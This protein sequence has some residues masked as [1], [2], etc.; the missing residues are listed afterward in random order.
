MYNIVIFASG[1]G[2]NAQRIAEYF[3]NKPDFSI[4]RIYCNTKNAGVIKRAE[5]L[6]IPVFIFNRNDFY[7]TQT[8]L[9]QIRSDQPNL[10]VLA[11]FLW[12]IPTNLTSL[13][14]NRII[15]IHPALLPKYGGKGMYGSFVHQAVL[16]NKEKESGITI[17]YV[18]EN[19][20]EGEIIF[21]D[22]CP[23]YPDDDPESL[24]KRIHELEYRNY[25]VIIERLL[26]S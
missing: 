10:I 19:Y 12:L 9:D 22:R 16:Q 21:Q 23:V 17:H 3:G 26:G 13:Y 15:N 24:A 4:T 18:N 7:N 25:P 14:P 2:T 8:V 11:G 5:K 1:S 20:D 6:N